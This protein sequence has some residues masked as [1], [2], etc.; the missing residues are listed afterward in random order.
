M[1]GKFDVVFCINGVEFVDCRAFL[2]LGDYLYRRIG[3]DEHNNCD[4]LSSGTVEYICITEQINFNT[5]LTENEMNL[6]LS[7]GYNGGL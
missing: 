7:G 2:R 5:L 1:I 4:I 3:A 6:E